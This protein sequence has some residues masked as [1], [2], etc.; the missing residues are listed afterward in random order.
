MKPA[1]WRAFSFGGLVSPPAADNDSTAQSPPWP[2][3]P[4]LRSS[5][6]DARLI[7][8]NAVSQAIGLE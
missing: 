2:L 1:N 8:R 3:T 5:P 6:P 7:S 4:P